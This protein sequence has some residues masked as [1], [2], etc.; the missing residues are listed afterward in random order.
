ME[1]APYLVLHIIELITTSEELYFAYHIMFGLCII[2]GVISVCSETIIIPE[3]GFLIWH[4][5]Y[6]ILFM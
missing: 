3:R 2:T 6:Y 1:T 4:S 5:H